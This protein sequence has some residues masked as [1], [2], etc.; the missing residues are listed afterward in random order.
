[1]L[2]RHSVV[3][4]NV[5][6]QSLLWLGILWLGIWVGI[7]TPSSKPTPMFC[8]PPLLSTSG[9]RPT[10]LLQGL[11]LPPSLVCAFIHVLAR[12]KPYIYNLRDFKS[13]Q[14]I[15]HDP[16]CSAHTATHLWC[17]SFLFPQDTMWE[18][19]LCLCEGSPMSVT[20][21][22][23]IIFTKSVFFFSFPQAL[24]CVDR[25]RREKITGVI[26]AKNSISQHGKG[27]MWSLSV[28]VFLLRG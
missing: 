21:S 28:P 27:R 18:H 24:L 16:L 12:F 3:V 10:A 1:M 4:F 19:P 26:R 13:V 17:L 15:S 11:A 20:G 8:T 5:F 23:I 25:W 6:V 2:K 9:T 14:E 22:H 7:F